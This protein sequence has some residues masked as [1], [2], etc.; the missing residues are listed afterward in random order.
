MGY[1]PGQD[2]HGLILTAA[3]GGG[4]PLVRMLDGLRLAAMES[5]YAY[6]A[7]FKGG[8]FIGSE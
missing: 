5:F 4:P 3:G 1:L 2:R 7:A 6:S 8:V